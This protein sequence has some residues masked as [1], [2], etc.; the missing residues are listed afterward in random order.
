ML[1]CTLYIL[2]GMALTST[3]IELIRRQ[4]AESWR[5][6]A[7][8]MSGPLLAEGLKKLMMA[9]NNAADVASL[10]RILTVK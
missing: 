1:L 8:A 6:I 10:Q 7:Q 5:R 2:I 4:Y 3:F 9:Q